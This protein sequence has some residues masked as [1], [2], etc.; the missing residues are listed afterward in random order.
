MSPKT[1]VS[2]AVLAMVMGLGSPALAQTSPTTPAPGG[3]SSQDKSSQ[4]AQVPPEKM[5]AEKVMPSPQTAAPSGEQMT[6]QGPNTV[7]GSDLIGKT[8]YGPDQKKIGTVNDIILKQDGS[9]I[10][11]VIVG[12]GGFLGLGEHNVAM[13]M[14]KFSFR[15]SESGRM[16]TVLNASKEDLEKV[17]AFKTKADLDAEATRNA[18][19]PSTPNPG[20]APSK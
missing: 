12:V 18:P 15:P 9:G 5:P 6:T 19:R 1:A 16:V 11:G 4:A 8:V 20:S 3:S 2:V 13:K 7:L 10:E 17:P 14:D